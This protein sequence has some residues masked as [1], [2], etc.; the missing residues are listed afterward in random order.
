[1]V[2]SCVALSIGVD[3]GPKLTFPRRGRSYI[4]L[5]TVTEVSFTQHHKKRLYEH[6]IQNGSFTGIQGSNIDR[7]R[8]RSVHILC[9]YSVPREACDNETGTI[10]IC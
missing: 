5:K 10:W 1:M 7:A 8:L 4:P 9:V 6:I 2:E 3:L